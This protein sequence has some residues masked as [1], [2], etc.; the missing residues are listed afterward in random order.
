[1][2]CRGEQGEEHG[3]MA[4][5]IVYLGLA[6][7]PGEPLLPSFEQRLLAHREGREGS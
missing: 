4:M 1:M 6:E 2:V 5:V 7:L 3:S